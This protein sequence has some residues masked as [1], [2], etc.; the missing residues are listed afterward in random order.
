MP[1]RV[2]RYMPDGSVREVWSDDQATRLRRAGFVPARASR[3]EAIA[4]GEH[5]GLF[6]VDFTPLAEVAGDD[7][8][9]VC[10]TRPFSLY[11]TARSAEVAW[12]EA[13]YVLGT[14]ERPGTP[15]ELLGPEKSS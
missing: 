2:T 11:D 4:E 13:H 15:A 14:P 6:H 7:S 10:L 3:F 5:A 1:T 9:R 12:L 8:F